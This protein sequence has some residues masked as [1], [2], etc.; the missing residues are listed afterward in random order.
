VNA[1]LVA[2]EPLVGSFRFITREGVTSGIHAGVRVLVLYLS[3]AVFLAVVSAEDIARGLSALVEPVSPQL[4]RRIAMY[5]FISFGF[6]PLFVDELDR[7]KAA[8]RFRGGGLGGGFVKKL[9]G[10]RLLVVPLFISAIHRA[11]QLAMTVELRRIRSRIAGI[12]VLDD[13]SASDYLF[14]AITVMVVVAALAAF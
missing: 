5:G 2:G 3:T 6:L 7:I 12:L 9:E 11:E 10:A 1:V 8:Q 13:P 14:V 4:A